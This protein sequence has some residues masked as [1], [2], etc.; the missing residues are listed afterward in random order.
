MSAETTPVTRWER[1]LYFYRNG[2]AGGFFT[3]LVDAFLHAD[4]ENTLRLLKAFPDELGPAFRYRMESGYWEDLCQ[5]M[6]G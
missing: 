1:E 2:T 4:S 5:R 6:K 3:K